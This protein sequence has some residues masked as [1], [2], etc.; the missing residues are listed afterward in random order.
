MAALISQKKNS[1][2]PSELLN[3]N[4]AAHKKKNQKRHRTTPEMPQTYHLP[5]RLSEALDQL[6]LHTPSE[7]NQVTSDATHK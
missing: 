3:N 1:S 2:E 4:R 7:T 6:P 5:P